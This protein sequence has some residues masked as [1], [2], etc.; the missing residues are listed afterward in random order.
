MSIPG[1]NV[2]QQLLDAYANVQSYLESER[3][4]ILNAKNQRDELN[5]DRGKALDSLAEHYLPELSEQAIAKT[6]TEV[7][8]GMTQILHRQREHLRRVELEVADVNQQRQKLD[9]QLMKLNEDLDRTRAEQD[10]IAAK[11]EQTLRGDTRFAELSDR[12]AVA[13]ATLER[14]E[15]NLQEIDQESARKLPAYEQSALFRYLYERGF[16]T[17]RYTSRGFTRRMDRWL[18]RYIDYP[19]AKQSYEFLS[20][21]PDQMRR[22]IAEDRQ[23]L[24]TVMLELERRRDHVAAEYG[25]P[26]AIEKTNQLS[27]QRQ[28]LLS[29]IDQVAALTNEKNAD[30]TDVEDLRGTYYRDAIAMFRKFLNGHEIS[31]LR[32]RAER[33]EDVTDD[34]IVARLTGVDVAIDN[35]DE[36]ARQQRAKLDEIQAFLGGLA[37]VIQRFRAAQFDSARSNFLSSLNIDEEVTL[38]HEQGNVD[39]LWSRIRRAQ[40]WGAIDE[41][42]DHP[43]INVMQQVLV[44][45]MTQAAGND[46]TEPARRAGDRRGQQPTLPGNP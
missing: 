43:T 37:R 45:A 17:D 9:Q 6:W 40:R 41:A 4:S 8:D 42:N 12:A 38:A 1:P 20:K 5:V 7:R 30:R 25:L 2:H 3:S 19:R 27:Q 18:G 15:A 13:E 23:S 39:E 21:T 14:A 16:G 31:E 35:V 36:A 11:V 22:I 26:K 29:S 32:R 24:E 33:T 10:T 44:N 34:Q 28:N 46:R